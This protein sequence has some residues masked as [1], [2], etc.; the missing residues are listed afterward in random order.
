MHPFAKVLIALGAILLMLGGYR[1]YQEYL[2][3][4]YG[5]QTEGILLEK[6]IFEARG[7]RSNVA[8]H[9]NKVFKYEYSDSN[10]QKHY[11][12]VT[13]DDQ[14]WNAFGEGDKIKVK[15]LISN[16]YRSEISGGLIQTARI[17]DSSLFLI[18]GLIIIL[19]VSAYEFLQ[20]KKR[21]SS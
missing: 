2:F 6:Q 1:L 10:S 15:Y 8:V 14:T 16:P 11:A 19:S 7:S 21:P 4:N 3:L 20:S 12:E 9:Y 17:V 13:V 18:G 5:Q